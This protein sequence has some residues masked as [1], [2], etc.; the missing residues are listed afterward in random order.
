PVFD[1][2]RFLTQLLRMRALA[3]EMGSA[4]ETV[5]GLR[6]R[7]AAGD[8]LEVGGYELASRLAQDIEALAPPVAARN[9]GSIHWIDVSS[10]PCEGAARN[11]KQKRGNFKDAASLDVLGLEGEPFWSTTE[12]V[13]VPWLVSTSAGIL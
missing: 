8:I 11:I 10:H 9:L 12:L 6:A 2:K 4:R 7:L 5:S 13:D 1:G 3:S